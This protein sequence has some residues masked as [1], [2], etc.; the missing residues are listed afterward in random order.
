MGNEKGNT[1]DIEDA[2]PAMNNIQRRKSEGRTL[3]AHLGH[4]YRMARRA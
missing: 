4:S 3:E 2:A 1:Y